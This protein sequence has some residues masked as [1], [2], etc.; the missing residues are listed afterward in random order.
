MDSFSLFRSL[1]L[2][3]SI[4]KTYGLH[5]CLLPI[6]SNPDSSLSSAAADLSSLWTKALQ[7]RGHARVSSVD[8]SHNAT[9]LPEYGKRLSE[10][11]VKR[12]KGFV[13][14]LTAQ[15]LVPFMER[16]VQQWNEQV[17]GRLE[18][19]KDRFFLSNEGLFL[20]TFPFLIAYSS[21]HPDGVLLGNSSVLVES[22]LEARVQDLLLQVKLFHLDMILRTISEFVV[23]QSDASSLGEPTL[24]L[25]SRLLTLSL[26]I[27]ILSLR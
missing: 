21:L 15:S 18:T 3:E 2:L 11:D 25:L 14:E 12:L 27:A 4:K 5:C 22:S 24:T 19:D 26:V 16:C 13:R 23:T 7:P 6:N 10:E 9:S 20:S 8:S 17:S 1:S